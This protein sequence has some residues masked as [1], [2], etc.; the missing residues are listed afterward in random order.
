MDATLEFVAR[1][2]VTVSALSLLTF[3]LALLAIERL[4]HRSAVVERETGLLALVNYAGILGFV[5]VA[6]VSA[7]TM[8]GTVPAPAGPPHAALVIAGTVALAAAG[9]LSVWGYR[10]LGRDFSSEAEVRSDTALVTGG[11]FRVVRHPMYLSILLLWGG[12]ALALFSPVMAV[13]CLVLVPAFVARS[14]AEER[15]LTRHF[16]DAYAAYAA[17]VPMLVPG[18]P[19][20]G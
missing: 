5:G 11:A 1:A 7:V 2:V 4:S 20:R 16:G 17:R 15:L 14:R 12:S 10:S 9:L 8:L 19:A 6:L 13:C 18:W 3:G